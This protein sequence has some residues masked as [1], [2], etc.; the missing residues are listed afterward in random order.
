M[1]TKTPYTA[2]HYQN[3]G[4]YTSCASYR[5]TC[6]TIFFFTIYSLINDMIFTFCKHPHGSSGKLRRISNQFNMSRTIT[7][8][9]HRTRKVSPTWS[10]IPPWDRNPLSFIPGIKPSFP[11]VPVT[12]KW[13]A[14]WWVPLLL[15]L[16]L[17]IIH[18]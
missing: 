4:L 6:D 7:S 13:T 15:L 11:Q 3:T 2:L 14:I 9:L 12:C 18:F 16:L 5:G 1:Y 10:C 8:P 17:Q